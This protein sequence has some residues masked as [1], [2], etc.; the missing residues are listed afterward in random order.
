MGSILS[1]NRWKSLLEISI[2]YILILLI[3]YILGMLMAPLYRQIPGQLPNTDYV[4]FVFTCISYGNNM[5]VYAVWMAFIF[6]VMA[7]K[8]V[9]LSSYGFNLRNLDVSL[10]II[11]ICVILL[12]IFYVIQFLLWPVSYRN[13]IDVI[14]ITIVGL[15]LLFVAIKTSKVII[16]KNNSIARYAFLILP[17]L[18]AVTMIAIPTFGMPPLSQLTAILAFISFVV[19]VGAGE[20]ILF[21]GFFQSRL[22]EV[23]GRPYW[24]FGV[25]WGPGLVISAVLFS[26][27]HLGHVI[28]VLALALMGGLVY[29]FIREKTGSI[30]APIVIHGTLDYFMYFLASISILYH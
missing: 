4:R 17:I 21:R 9:D 20:E 5:L 26:M 8:K 2:V 18:A 16:N 30:V 22:N 24:T 3:P 29:G 27:Y 6:V 10:K 11:A 7:L 13:L 12:S 28:P 25:S 19:F 14:L 23:F 15:F 1:G